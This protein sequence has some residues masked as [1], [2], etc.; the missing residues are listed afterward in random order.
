MQYYVRKRSHNI[1][2]EDQSH[3]CQ[4]ERRHRGFGEGQ[5]FLFPSGCYELKLLKFGCQK[6]VLI[7]LESEF[8]GPKTAKKLP[9]VK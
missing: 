5:M 4:Y 1:Y 3:P 7:I 6:K 9:K 2:V 8:F